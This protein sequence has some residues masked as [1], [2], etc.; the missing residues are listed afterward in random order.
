MLPKEYRCAELLTRV[1]CTG[2]LN[3][4]APA[5]PLDALI[6]AVVT[7]SRSCQVKV[8]FNNHTCWGHS[9]GTGWLRIASHVLPHDTP[10]RELSGLV[11]N[12]LLSDFGIFG[13]EPRDSAL[14]RNAGNA[15]YRV[16]GLAA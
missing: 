5:V 10:H 11:R 7:Q 15:S 6:G 2:D 3:P 12:H 9:P 1:A 16:G 4:M 13:D 14:F 8:F